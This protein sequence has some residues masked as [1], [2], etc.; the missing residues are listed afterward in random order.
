MTTIK[1]G[2]S[3]SV[4]DVTDENQLVVR[5]IIEEEIEHA[6]TEGAAYIWYSG[7]AQDLAA[8]DTFLFIRNDGDTP[9]ILDRLVLLGSNVICT[10]SIHIANATTTPAGGSVVTGVNMNNRF[11][12]TAADVTA[13]TGETAVADG[14]LAEQIITAV[15]TTE[16]HSLL[17][18]ILEKGQYIQINQDTESSSGST[19]IV[20][21][22]EN[23]S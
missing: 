21:H 6:S 5:A 10:W 4:A 1:S 23:P 15:T 17:G 20:G 11:S 22:F 7:A 13:R 14:T 9:L 3:G 12:G 16:R 2:S 18:Y 19:T 8:G